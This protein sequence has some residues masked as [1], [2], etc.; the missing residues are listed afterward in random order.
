MLGGPNM[1][2]RVIKLVESFEVFDFLTK[3]MV[4]KLQNDQHEILFFEDRKDAT[5]NVIIVVVKQEKKQGFCEHLILK[6]VIHLTMMLEPKVGYC[7]LFE[8]T[9]Q[10]LFCNFLEDTCLIH[11][12]NYDKLIYTTLIK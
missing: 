9:G 1:D 10:N 11:N 4:E 3:L 8:V 7:K 6:A 2:Y 5:S 12:K